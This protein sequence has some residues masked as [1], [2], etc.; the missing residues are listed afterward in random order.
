M[1]TKKA[2]LVS[3]LI[4][5]KEFNILLPPTKNMESE[6][7]IP[8]EDALTEIYPITCFNT[9]DNILRKRNHVLSLSSIK[10]G[11][12]FEGSALFYYDAFLVIFPPT[13]YCFLF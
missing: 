12:R 4:T 7:L 13:F 2:G 8:F 9:S 1:H 5:P 6:P 10:T 11:N 3:V